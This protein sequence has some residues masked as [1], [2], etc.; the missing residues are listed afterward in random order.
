MSCTLFNI[1]AG[2]TTLV[3]YN[4]D[5]F[6]GGGKIWFIPPKG[7]DHGYFITTRF[8]RKF[9]Y[10]GMNDRGLY[11]CQTA[12][13]VIKSSISFRKKW[14][15]STN[16]IIRILERCATLAEA[17]SLFDAHSVIF[18]TALGFVMAH[19]M[20]VEPSGKSA[21]IEVLPGGN[22]VYP[23]KGPYQVIT[24]FY[25]SDPSIQW[26]NFVP[27]CGGYDRFDTVESRLNN[28][29]E[30]SPSLLHGILEAAAMNDWRYDGRTWNTVFSNV[31]DLNRREISIVYGKKYGKARHFLLDA[32]LAKGIHHYDAVGF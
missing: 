32:E 3:G 21:V 31:H 17:L 8:G 5:W 14:A 20:V 1:T 22:R 30:I 6:S 24:N 27:G 23:K 7:D 19:F 18:G 13:P 4:F 16:I 26:P 11:V 12:V 29:A 2:G 28:A 15:I 25:L 9:P 10:E